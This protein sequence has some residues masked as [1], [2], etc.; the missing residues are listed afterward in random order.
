MTGNPNSMA[1][2]YIN[3]SLAEYLG[4]TFQQ[5][6]KYENGTNRVTAGRLNEIAKVLKV[7]VA[8]FFEGQENVK[9]SVPSAAALMA[10]PNV[11]PMVKAF[12]TLPFAS[13]RAVVQLVEAMAAEEHSKAV[14]SSG[15]QKGR[16]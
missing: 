13:Q 7:S 5:V 2:L 12:S 14:A 15:K 9:E 6:Q 16:R 1:N 8:S 4:V 10:Q 11:V 3:W